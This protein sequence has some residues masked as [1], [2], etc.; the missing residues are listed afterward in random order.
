MLPD[1]LGS[2]ET[3][4]IV[5]QGVKSLAFRSCPPNPLPQTKGKK[6]KQRE[7][8]IGAQR[9]IVDSQEIH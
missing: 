4:R 7:V 6:K 5:F 8:D 9:Q 2:K 3:G 1:D